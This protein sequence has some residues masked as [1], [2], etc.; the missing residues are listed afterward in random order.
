MIFSYL[1]DREKIQPYI[2][3]KSEDILMRTKQPVPFRSGSAPVAVGLYFILRHAKM[4]SNVKMMCKKLCEELCEKL[5]SDVTDVKY[6]WEEAVC[7]SG[8]R[9]NVKEIKL[10]KIPKTPKEKKSTYIQ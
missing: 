1:A 7:S 2:Y 4:F 3:I 9:A 6:G 10:Q 5:N 8:Q